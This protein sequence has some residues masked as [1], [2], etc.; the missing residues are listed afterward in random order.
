VE[1]GRADVALRF[2]EPQATERFVRVAE[3]A[4]HRE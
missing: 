1:A 4:A 2:A 3:A